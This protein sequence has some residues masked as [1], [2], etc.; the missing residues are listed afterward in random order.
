VEEMYD[1]RRAC[2]PLD[3]VYARVNGWSSG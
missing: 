3:D 2:R 1:Y